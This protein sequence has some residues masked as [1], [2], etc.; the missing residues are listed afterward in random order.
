MH[1]LHDQDAPDLIE[2][3]ALP[4]QDLARK[5][6]VGLRGQNVVLGE[7]AVG[8]VF[9]NRRSRDVE[10]IQNHDDA[11]D[12]AIG[13]RLLRQ[14]I[15]GERKVSL[16]RIALGEIA[17]AVMAGEPD[18]IVGEFQR[19][20]VGACEQERPCKQGTQT[21]RFPHS[22]A[23]QADNADPKGKRSFIA[24]RTQITEKI[25][26]LFEIGCFQALRDASMDGRE[27]SGGVFLFALL[28]QKPREVARRAQLQCQ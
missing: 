13:L 16:A 12:P 24:F 25:G 5:H 26:D 8:L 28:E 18:E 4:R 20:A 23:P 6:G 7:G 3:H 9:G 21:R 10:R 22:H 15:A 27:A 2:R 19:F 1:R 14:K 11:R 17:F